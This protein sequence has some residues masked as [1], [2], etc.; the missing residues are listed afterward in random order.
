MEA[1]LKTEYAARVRDMKENKQCANTLSTPSQRSVPHFTKDSTSQLKSYAASSSTLDSSSKKAS[2]KRKA[3]D[4]VFGVYGVEV[5]DSYDRK[6][7]GDGYYDD[8]DDYDQYM[9]SQEEVRSQPKASQPSSSAA[10]PSSSSPSSGERTYSTPA[11]QPPTVENY[12]F[13][14]VKYLF[15]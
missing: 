10:A 15:R 11:P 9:E 14:F 6:S 13:S 7:N 1:E 8:A 5:E 4:D 3:E 12:S 2:S